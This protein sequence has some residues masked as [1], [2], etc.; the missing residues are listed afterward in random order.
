MDDSIAAV[1]KSNQGPCI[2]E[3]LYLGIGHNNLNRECQWTAGVKRH[4]DNA[5]SLSPN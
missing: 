3:L 1:R 2:F 5:H 4:D